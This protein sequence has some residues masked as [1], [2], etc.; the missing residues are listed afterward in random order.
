MFKNEIQKKIKEGSRCSETEIYPA[1][2]N[3]NGTKSNETMT[4]ITSVKWHEQVRCFFIKPKYAQEKF[5]LE[6]H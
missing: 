5:L 2:I 1:L 4:I 6:I 3:I